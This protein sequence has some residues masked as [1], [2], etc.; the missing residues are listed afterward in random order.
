MQPGQQIREYVFEEEI[1]VGGMGAVWRARHSALPRTYAIKVMLEQLL[2]DLH[3]D[4]RERNQERFVQEALVQAKL[5]HPL[6][7]PIHDFFHEQG[8]YFIVM[9]LITGESL[10]E[11]LARGQLPVE[12]AL[13]I[14]FDVLDALNYAHQQGVIHRDVKPS[15]ILLDKQGRAH[16]TDFGIAILMG[17]RRKTSSGLA[18]GTPDYMSPEQIKRPR[19]VDHRT[20]VYSFGCVLYEMLTGR[21]PFESDDDEGDSEYSIKEQHVHTPPTPPRQFN[22][23][24]PPALEEIVLRALAKDRDQRFSGCGELAGELGQYKQR[25]LRPPTLVEEP[26]R[27]VV[28]PLTQAGGGSRSKRAIAE[29]TFEFDYLSPER[30]Q[31]VKRRGQAKYYEED[32]GGG[33]I[34]EMVSI[35]A[36]LFFMGSAAGSGYVNEKPQHQVMV[37]SFWMGRYPVTQA[38]W[39]AALKLPKVR[40]D[41]PPDPF[42]FKGDIHPVERVSWED[43]VEYCLRLS[44]YSGREYRLPSEAEWEY[45]C[46]AGTTTEYH[47]GDKIK[48]EWANYDASAFGLW[49][50]NKYRQRTTPVGHFSLANG[51]GLCDM[52]G[53]VWEWCEDQWH[54]SYNGAPSDGR[55]WV[56][57]S[58]TGSIRVYRGGGWGIGAVYCRSASRGGNSPGDRF[59]NLG[60][61]LVRVG[62]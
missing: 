32:L 50:S 55:A 41:L 36:G 24:L 49:K 46:R 34:L 30:G 5:E 2:R 10:E 7:V 4:R 53:N 33:V 31:T 8:Q 29:K 40:I 15:N 59:V 57:I 9:P 19:L 3:A 45:G 48:P 60:F 35:P 39:R 44:H 51:F 23:S 43:A 27:V 25:P 21:P 1:G 22:P 28:R 56:D 38:Q 12:E 11:R 47:F 14:S 61:R 16:L 20:D 52:H 13:Q 54:D 42:H 18:V 26:D 37:S 62:R 17:D 58:A 6:I